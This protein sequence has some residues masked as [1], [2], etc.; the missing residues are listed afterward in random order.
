MS[1]QAALEESQK[2]SSINHKEVECTEVGGQ[3]GGGG[4]G[5]GPSPP[6]KTKG[7]G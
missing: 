7:G 2:G 4:G 5:G 3:G 6:F 1:E